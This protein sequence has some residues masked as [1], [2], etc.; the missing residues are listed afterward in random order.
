MTISCESSA[1]GQFEGRGR[2]SRSYFQGQ[3]V[4][5]DDVSGLC[6]QQFDTCQSSRSE[7]QG[8]TSNVKWSSVEGQGRKV[9][10]ERSK[11]RVWSRIR[12]L[13]ACQ[14]SRSKGQ[15]QKVEVISSRSKG[16]SSKV[17]VNLS[18]SEGQT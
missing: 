5:L 14:S 15:G 18:R 3:K 2:R 1:G 12:A 17:K 9:K 10:V 4:K 11:S 7:G 6:V 8:R 13:N 16:H